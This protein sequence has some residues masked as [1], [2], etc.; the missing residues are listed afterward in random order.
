[1]IGSVYGAAF[2]VPIA[3]ALYL[4]LPEVFAVQYWRRVSASPR[5]ELWFAAHSRA[6][7]EEMASL[8]SELVIA[9]HRTGPPEP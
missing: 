2:V 9:V 4:G 6:A 5:G 7:P 3:Y 8:A 1:V